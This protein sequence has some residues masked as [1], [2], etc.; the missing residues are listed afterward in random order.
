MKIEISENHYYPFGL[1]LTSATNNNA[2]KNTKK[3][4]TIELTKDLGVELYET[5]LRGL[6]PQIGRWWQI[7]SKPKEW[8][9]PYASMSDNPVL[10]TD[11]RGDYDR[12]ENGWQRFWNGFTG[13][14]YLNQA[15]ADYQSRQKAGQAVFYNVKNGT[16][17][18]TQNMGYEVGGSTTKGYTQY[19]NELISKYTKYEDYTVPQGGPKFVEGFKNSHEGR[20]ADVTRSESRKNLMIYTGLGEVPE[21]ELTSFAEQIITLNKATEGGGILLNGNP[22]TAI[23]TALYYETAAEQGSAIFRSISNG[24]MFIDGNKRT[25]VAAFQLFA[26]QFGL[27]TVSEAQMTQVA[28]QVATGEIT[29]VSEIAK[30]LTK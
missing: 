19:Q 21:A 16:A 5:P 15:W 3:Y 24:H 20:Y 22:T 14:G 4:Q 1:T 26:E 18:I 17:T 9:S 8:M 27:T 11:P 28:T 23:N 2:E 6:D 30:L 12:P 7:D 29:D 10:N 13:R 25:A